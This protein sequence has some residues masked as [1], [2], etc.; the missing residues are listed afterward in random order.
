MTHTQYGILEEELANL[1]QS[2]RLASTSQD[3][4]LSSPIN[5]NT[6]Q[7]TFKELTPQ[8]INGDR[9]TSGGHVASSQTMINID[10]Q[11]HLPGINQHNCFGLLCIATVTALSPLKTKFVLYVFPL[12]LVISC[13]YVL[14]STEIYHI[15]H[16]Y[17]FH[18][19]SDINHPFNHSFIYVLLFISST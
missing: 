4:H 1:A 7:P 19:K 18:F 5:M 9:T 11:L 15:I 12:F 14:L 3:T 13:F 2:M 10:E 16:F 8:L 6:P 17:Q